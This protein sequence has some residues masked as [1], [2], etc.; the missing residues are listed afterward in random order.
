MGYVVRVGMGFGLTFLG[1]GVMWIGVAFPFQ[2]LYSLV[3]LFA[4]FVSRRFAK[5]DLEAFLP[6]AIGALPLAALFVQFRDPS[7]S[8]LWPIVIVAS[9]AVDLGLG[10]FLGR[11]KLSF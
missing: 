6:I 3:F 9:W 4:G 5:D 7:G 10:V 2:L 11:K 8:H 1:M